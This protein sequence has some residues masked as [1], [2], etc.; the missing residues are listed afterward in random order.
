VLGR[1]GETLIGGAMRLDV[2][3]AE[4]AI[5]TAIARPL[6]LD[7]YEAAAAI[8]K[9]A[10]ANMADA[11]RLMSIQRG[12]DPRDFALVVF[13]G[14]GPLHG[15]ELARELS[16]PTVLVPPNPGV[17]SALGCL[18]VDVRH[19]LSTMLVGR[20]DTARLDDVEERF[21]S[22]EDEARRR[23]SVEGF[24]DAQIRLDRTIDMRYLGQ[25]RSLSVAI[26]RPVTSL[27]EAI[28]RFHETHEREHDYRRDD[29]P[30]E[31]YRLNIRATGETQKA[32][33]PQ[34]NTRATALEPVRVR[35]VRFNDG[36]DAIEAPVY[37]RSTMGAGAA[38][39][40]P[41]VVEQLD[42]T[43]L[44]PPGCE[45]VVDET[46]NIRIEAGP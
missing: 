25:W 4:E 1:L 41:A 36:G 24:A 10:N 5:T 15:V 45:A 16:I 32:Q 37:D 23:L 11:V 30:V 44:L 33:L 8:I 40:G 34:S 27:D 42:S 14:A 12:Y 39:T 31:I 28:A 2:R 7:L 22:L 38:L 43:I 9:V 17:T 18:L 46:L 6:G 29:T 26:G 19:D 35:L 13:G 21:Q 3:A 20:A